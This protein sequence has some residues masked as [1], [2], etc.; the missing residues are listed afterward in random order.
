MYFEQMSRVANAGGKKTTLI[1]LLIKT[2]EVLQCSQSQH[3]IFLIYSL[4]ILA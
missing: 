4:I 2:G 1:T 3:L